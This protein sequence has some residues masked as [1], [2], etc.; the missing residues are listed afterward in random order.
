V[1]EIDQREQFAAIAPAMAEGHYLVP[2]V[3][4]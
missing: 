3:I 2:R 4:E 1:T